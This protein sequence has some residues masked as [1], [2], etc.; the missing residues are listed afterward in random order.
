MDSKISDTPTEHELEQARAICRE[1]MAMF[2]A[3]NPRLE[4]LRLEL[5]EIRI[6]RSG[7]SAF[8][9]LYRECRE[10]LHGFVNSLCQ[11]LG[12]GGEQQINS[13]EG[14]Q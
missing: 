14:E 4:A 11:R 7:E 5:K 1:I 3:P 9:A 2:T 13:G 6:A 8:E 10:K 12:R